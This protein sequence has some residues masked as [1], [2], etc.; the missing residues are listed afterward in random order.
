KV[1]GIQIEMSFVPS[2]QGAIT[3]DEMKT[4]LNQKGFTLLALENGFYDKKTGRQL[5]VDGVFYR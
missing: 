1:T 4:K 5:E 2:Y 3:F